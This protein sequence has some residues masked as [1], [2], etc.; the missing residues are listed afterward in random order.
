MTTKP[1]Q[2]PPE[3]QAASN[4]RDDAG[5]DPATVQNVIILPYVSPVTSE[6][7]AAPG[8]TPSHWQ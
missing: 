4:E 3:A 8:P 2:A 5:R 1:E 7:P 6:P